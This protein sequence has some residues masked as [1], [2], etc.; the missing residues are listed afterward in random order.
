MNATD[1]RIQ[2]G[3][4][5]RCDRRWG[6]DADGP[7]PCYKVYYPVSGSARMELGGRERRLAAG[8]LYFL[9]GYALGRF[10][11]APK[12]DVYWLHFVADS[13]ALDAALRRAAPFVA[14][15]ARVAEAWRSVLL[16]LSD[17]VPASPPGEFRLHAMLLCLAADLLEQTPQPVS[18][19]SAAL[20]DRLA[21]A[22]RFMDRHGARN[23]SLA[24]IAA[25]VALAP[26]YFHR[27]FTRAFGLSPHAYMLRRRMNV[28]REL[29]LSTDL[30]VGQV[31]ARAGYDCPFYFS[32]AFKKH[33]R[34]N[35]SETRLSRGP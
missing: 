28:A 18:D 14:W 15:P 19:P 33:F 23:P 2:D 27:R 32:R 7:H 6:P 8:K 9:S 17:G 20:R 31:A 12:M 22:V 11:A 5:H 21:P 13:P 34:V 1:L 35:P 25:A 29:L 3:G 4:F 10:R 26:T 24:E 16:G 30:P